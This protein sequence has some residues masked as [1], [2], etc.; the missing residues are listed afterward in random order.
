MES[1]A[2]V[3]ILGL[4]LTVVRLKVRGLS[5]LIYKGIS[6][7]RSCLIFIVVPG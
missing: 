3:L 7:L 2:L 1:P 5:L 6:F 4:P